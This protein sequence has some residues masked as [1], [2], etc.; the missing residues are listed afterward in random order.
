MWKRLLRIERAERRGDSLVVFGERDLEPRAIEAAAFAGRTALVV[1]PTGWARELKIGAVHPGD[2]IAVHFDTAIE[3]GDLAY[4]MVLVSAELVPDKPAER[5]AQVTRAKMAGAVGMPDEET[6]PASPSRVAIDGWR[7]ALAKASMPRGLGSLLGMAVGDALGTTHEFKALAAPAFPTLATGPLTEVVGAGAFRLAAGEVTDDTQMAAA[8][9]YPFVMANRFATSHYV[10]KY[11]AWQNVAFDIGITVRGGLDLVAQGVPPERAGRRVW[12]EHARNAAGNGSL[13]RTAVLG[14]MLAGLPDARRLASFA[15]SAITH[16]DP[17]CQIACAAL[18]AAIAHALT[19]R[20]SPASM[21][22]A[23]EEEVRAAAAALRATFGDL[24]SEIDAA[25]RALLADLAAARDDD[26]DLYGQEL[27]LHEMAGFVRV[28]FR[29]A[30]WELL[31][32]PSFA[33]GVIDVA[34]RGGDADT[35]AAITGALL[36]AFYGLDGLP[37]RW[38][39]RVLTAPVMVADDWE[40]HPRTLV[41]A[42]AHAFSVEQSARAIVELA[43]I[44]ALAFPE[45]GPILDGPP[46][47]GEHIAG[48]IVESWTLGRARVRDFAGKPTLVTVVPKPVSPPL[49]SAVRIQ[50]HVLHVDGALILVMEEPPAGVPLTIPMLPLRPRDALPLLVSLL[51]LVRD[52]GAP[53]RALTVDSIYI[54]DNLQ[55]SSVLAASEA[56]APRAL[57]RSLQCAAPEILAGGAPSPAGAVFS[58]CGAYLYAV[59]RH[60][61]YRDDGTLD[62]GVPPSLAPPLADAIRRALDADPA[63]RPA[64]GELLAIL[65]DNPKLS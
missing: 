13:M 39:Q 60:G 45:Y 14:V 28:A 3:P 34:N 48:M 65:T 58:A 37:Q 19:A 64:V 15:D 53:I 25:E 44:V 47:S 29:L 52:A 18:N 62:V 33:A 11:L 24:G 22:R 59:R 57:R 46:E 26:P 35:N 43:P 63:K 40:Y 49:P 38:V 16:F 36:G 6:G 51:E 31:H 42:I 12:E 61:P 20:P 1:W 32:A 5:G 54:G 10:T 30:F 23:A 8:L 50:P 56:Y 17:R 4:G 7:E 55:L 9:A 41:R 27:H 21:A 2:E